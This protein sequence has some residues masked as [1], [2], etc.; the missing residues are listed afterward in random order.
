LLA[1]RL[2]PAPID[3]ALGAKVQKLV[4]QMDDD[5]FSAREHASQQAAEL[6]E[7][8]EPFL[9]EALKTTISA[10]ARHR[11]RRLLADIAGKPMVLTSDQQRAIRAVQ[12]LEHIGGGEAREV[13]RRL[14]SGQPSARLTQEAKNAL[15]R[16][17]EQSA[18]G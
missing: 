6:G 11:I 8:A 18:K 3:P 13:L 16:L 1:E 14:S 7:A 4:A 15:F 12:I 2:K 9:Q 5:L 17:D 10:E